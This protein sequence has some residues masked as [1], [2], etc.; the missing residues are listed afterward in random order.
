MWCLMD[1]KNTIIVGEYCRFL[2]YKR[3]LSVST[4]C[5]MTVDNIRYMYIIHKVASNSGKGE[6]P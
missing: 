4:L 5:T 6:Q 3:M 1:L 2:S